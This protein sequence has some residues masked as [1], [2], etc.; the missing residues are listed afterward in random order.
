MSLNTIQLPADGAG[1]KLFAITKSLSSDTVYM[2]V[3]ALVDAS[4][5]IISPANPIHTTIN[6]VYSGV[7]PSIVNV[8]GAAGTTIA[9][10]GSYANDGVAVTTNGLATQSYLYGYDGDAAK[11]N[12]L[13]VNKSGQGALVVASS[14]VDYVISKIS[15][16]TVELSVPS[17]MRVG[18]IQRVTGNSGGQVLYSGT[19]KSVSIKALN[20]DIY[21][22]DTTSRPYSGFGSLIE[23]NDGVSFDWNDLGTL[24]VV[25]SVSGSTITF[26]GV[27]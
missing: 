6:T 15:G 16:E 7:G 27:V 25:A 19:V 26:M 1:K 21:L 8:A 5:A 17:T 13:R 14:G 11:I 22:G 18:L 10:V 12:R 3:H 4:G 2:E 24:C 9:P 20:G 23:N